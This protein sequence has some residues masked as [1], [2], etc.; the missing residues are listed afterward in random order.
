LFQVFNCAKMFSNCFKC[1]RIVIEL[2]QF[3]SDSFT[4]QIV[5]NFNSARIFIADYFRELYFIRIFQASI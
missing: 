5:S 4:A 3:A 1:F 2:F